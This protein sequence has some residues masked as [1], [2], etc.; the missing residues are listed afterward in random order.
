MSAKSLSPLCAIH[1]IYM[2]GGVT[3]SASSWLGRVDAGGF[4][5]S[6][7]FGLIRAPQGGLWVDFCA[8]CLEVSEFVP[9]FASRIGLTSPER[10]T[11]Y[12]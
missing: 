9:I 10:L 8:D 3:L 1:Y 5:R 12:V 11:T 4:V 2:L 7:G 6:G